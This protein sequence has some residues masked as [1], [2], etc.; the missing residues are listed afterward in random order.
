MVGLVALRIGW[1]CRRERGQQVSW[2]AL[3]VILSPVASP[4]STAR[5]PALPFRFSPLVAATMAA[6][7]ALTGCWTGGWIVP[8]GTAMAAEVEV[9][10]GPT[11]PVPGKQADSELFEPFAM[12]FMA[13]G[14]MVLVEYT[15]GRVL[16]WSPQQGLKPVAGARQQAYVNGP[17]ADARFNKLHNLVILPSGKVVLS[18]HHNHTLRLWDPVAQTVTAYSGNG[19]QGP[20]EPRVSLAEARYN[21]PICVTATPDF[22]SLLVADIGNR[23]IRRI[24]LADGVVT[25][26]AGN[27]QKGHPT[28]GAV[29]TE[30]TLF[31]P[32]GA[33]QNQAGEIY[34]I[35]RGGHTLSKIDTEGRIYRLAGNGK[36]GL[37][38][39]SAERSQLNGPKHLCLAADQSLFLADDVNDA[40]R[41]Y[42]PETGILSTVDLG[43]YRVSRPHGVA[44]HE[45]WLY[46]ADSYHH[47]ILRVKLAP[48]LGY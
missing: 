10:I 12:E 35:D 23:V 3:N 47:R 7:V 43:P 5:M 16:T 9:L 4:V 27:G 33:L 24:D 39:G 44:V 29:A 28:D 30:T 31:D 38:D 15:G 42:D 25:V 1:G 21:E 8:T 22:S 20:A 32:R 11:E 17:A 41:H 40:I 14:T 18:E 48:G 6:V 36:A 37:V 2:G 19:Q 26:I 46:I 45:G 34:V 13:D